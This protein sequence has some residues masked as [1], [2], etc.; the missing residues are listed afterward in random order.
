[1]TW[2]N[3]RGWARCASGFAGTPDGKIEVS[4]NFF[5]RVET[6]DVLALAFTTIK[7]NKF[8]EIAQLAVNV[9][10]LKHRGPQYPGQ[11]GRG[12]GAYRQLRARASERNDAEEINCE[13]EHHGINHGA[14]TVWLGDES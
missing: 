10:G 13:G 7:G 2:H 8:S 11:R 4:N 1:M 14:H 9:T 3:F 5:S 6:F 12:A